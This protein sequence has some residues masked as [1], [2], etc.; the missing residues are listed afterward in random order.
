[1]QVLVDGF[2]DIDGAERAL[3]TALDI[4]PRD[5]TALHTLGALLWRA[6]YT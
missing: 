2:N 5:V 6:R 1:M 3:A 4:A